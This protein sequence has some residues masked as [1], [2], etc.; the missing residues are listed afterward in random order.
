MHLPGICCLDRSSSKTLP[1]WIAGLSG[2]AALLPR[3]RLPVASSLA[4]PQMASSALK[5]GL[6]PGRFSS[7]SPSPGVLRYSRI[8][9]LRWAGALSQ[10]TFKSQGSRDCV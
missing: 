3:H 5:S 6:Y 7:C 4:H 8:A 10:I 1:L 9:S 2:T